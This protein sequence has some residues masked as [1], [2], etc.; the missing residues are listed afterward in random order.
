MVLDEVLNKFVNID[1]VFVIVGEVFVC[2]HYTYSCIP[3]QT[4]EMPFFVISMKRIRMNLKVWT[5]G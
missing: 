4:R 5:K 3:V 1:K 2:L